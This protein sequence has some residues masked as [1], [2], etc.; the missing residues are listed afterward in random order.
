NNNAFSDVHEQHE[1]EDLSVILNQT[2]ASDASYIYENVQQKDSI[3]ENELKI[4]LEQTDNE[5]LL[6]WNYSDY[7]GD[8]EKEVF[9]VTGKEDIVFG[10]DLWFISSERIDYL[11][12]VSGDSIFVFAVNDN[13]KFFCVSSKMY[14]NYSRLWGVRDGTA[15]EM[16]ISNVGQQF[17]FDGKSD[18]KI[19]QSALDGMSLG[20][21]HTHKEYYFYYD[22]NDKCFYEYGGTEITVNDLLQFENGERIFNDIVDKGGKITSVLKRNNYIINVNYTIPETDTLQYFDWNYNITLKIHENNVYVIEENEGIYL[23]ALVPEIAVY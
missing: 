5:N 10:G 2:E 16:P 6:F 22:H 1:Q 14:E 8:K 9:A 19:T 13:T 20:G 11:G 23:P 18:F 15:V 3:N 17:T 21:G 12:E 4:L 7:D